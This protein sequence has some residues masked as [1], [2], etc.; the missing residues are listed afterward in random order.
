MLVQTLG[1]GMMGPGISI[2]TDLTEGVVDR[3]RT[4]P[5]H[6]SAYLV[7]HYLAELAGLVLSP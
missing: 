7:G 1:F 5:V 4:L 6:R 2:A 3:F